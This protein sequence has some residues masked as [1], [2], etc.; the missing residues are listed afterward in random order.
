MTLIMESNVVYFGQFS[1]REDVAEQFD[2]D[3]PADAEI[4][5]ATHDTPSYEGSAMVLFRQDG[6][7]WEVHGSHCSCMGLEDQ[8]GP[9]ETSPAALLHRLNEGTEFRS[10]PYDG[11][12]EDAAQRIATIIRDLNAA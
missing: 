11:M 2:C 9:E 12:D 1:S 3:I 4:L 6:K 7:L 8:W 10:S 5:F